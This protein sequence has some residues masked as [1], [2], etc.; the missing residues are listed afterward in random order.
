[1]RKNQ[2]N[3]RSKN[4]IWIFARLCKFVVIFRTRAIAHTHTINGKCSTSEISRNYCVKIILFVWLS[5]FTKKM[6]RNGNN[7]N[8]NAKKA[9]TKDTQYIFFG[10]RWINTPKFLS[11]FY[12]FVSS[13]VFF[14]LVFH[15]SS[16]FFF[17][18]SLCPWS[19]FTFNLKKNSNTIFG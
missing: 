18:L 12:C 9:T 3:K 11:L 13:F 1:M 6:M 8:N 14:F 15:S 10:T 5:S 7:E 17:T 2:N 4:S 16:V 19:I